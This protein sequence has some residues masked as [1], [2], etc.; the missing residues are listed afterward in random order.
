MKIIDI[1]QE[2]E[3]IS[4]EELA[5]AEY[6]MEYNP[7]DTTG[8]GYLEE[9]FTEELKNQYKLASDYYK[10]MENIDLNY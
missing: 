4:M 6:N 1:T 10:A 7:F 8:T 5:E 9:E 2:T 3:I